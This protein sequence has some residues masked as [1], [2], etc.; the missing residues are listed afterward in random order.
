M[1]ASIYVFRAWFTYPEDLSDRDGYQANAV[2]GYADFLNRLLTRV[3]PAFIACAFDQSLST[4]YR[5]EI[6]PAYKANREPAPEELKRQFEQC[7]QLTRSLGVAEYVS[8]RYEADDII[9]T[10]AVMMRECG[11]PVTVVTADKDLTQ[12]IHHDHDEWW[13]YARNIRLG[14][15]GVQDRFGVMPSVIADMLALAGDAVDNIPGIP[16]VGPK[17]AAGLLNRYGSLDGIYGNLANV[18]SC[19]MRGAKRIQSLLEKHEEDARLALL[20]TRVCE[21]VPVEAMPHD[22]GWDGVDEELLESIIEQIGFNRNRY[23]HWL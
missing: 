1:D 16:G 18:A 12:L 17:T 19:G 14:R 11:H 8:D 22:L 5:N 23:Q 3:K 13:D 4:S 10:L 9:A 2:Y 7:R 15:E 6:Y 20:L 21:D